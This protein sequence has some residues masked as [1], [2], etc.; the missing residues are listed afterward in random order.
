MS[1]NSFI[2]PPNNNYIWT[3]LTVL[4]FFLRNSEADKLSDKDHSPYQRPRSESVEKEGSFQD[5]DRSPGDGR[6]DRRDY[7]R[8]SSSRPSNSG[9]TLYCGDLPFTM[10]VEQLRAKMEP[11]GEVTSCTIPADPYTNQGRGFGFVT[12]ADAKGAD[13]AV[14]NFRDSEGMRVE[15]VHNVHPII[16][17]NNYFPLTQKPFL[18]ENSRTEPDQE[19]QPV[20]FI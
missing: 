3:L 9:N 14:A 20:E 13:D 11:F 12:F 19:N 17:K 16:L 1:T 5:Q 15:K 10:T 8:E 18:T 6:E 2:K 7:G 4:H